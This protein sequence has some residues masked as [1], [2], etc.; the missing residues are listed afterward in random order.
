M[1]RSITQDHKWIKYVYKSQTSPVSQ[2]LEDVFLT[3]FI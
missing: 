2:G 3:F 1:P